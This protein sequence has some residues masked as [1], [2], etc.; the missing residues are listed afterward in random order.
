MFNFPS[1][2]LCPWVPHERGVQVN[3][4]HVPGPLMWHKTLQRD[5]LL[6]GRG[7]TF[8][9]PECPRTDLT[10]TLPE[11]AGLSSCL[12]GI[13]F[14]LYTLRASPG[15]GPGSRVPLNLGSSSARRPQSRQVLHGSGGKDGVDVEQLSACSESALSGDGG[16]KG[17]DR[18]VLTDTCQGSQHG[19][20]RP[21]PW[22]R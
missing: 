18:S 22:G 4:L 1:M 3:L 21:L 10:H 19:R 13:L 7:V 17:K 20:H 11:R 2:P 12:S 6:W 8:S 9:S 15:S 5:S 16:L 14:D